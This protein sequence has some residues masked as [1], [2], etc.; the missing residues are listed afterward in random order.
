MQE[1]LPFFL[2]LFSGVFFSEFFRRLHVPWVAALVLGGIIIGPFGLGLFEASETM[3]FIGEIGLIFLM[4][5]AG[6]ET[7]LSSF[8]EFR[9]DIVTFSFFNTIIPFAVG[10]GIAYI[11][12]LGFLPALLIGTIF[13]SSSIPVISPA[14][15][16]IGII[17]KRVGQSII[18]STIV[19]DVISL[20]VLSVIIQTINPTTVLPLWLFYFLLVIVLFVLRWGIGR[21]Q[22]LFALSASKEAKVVFQEELRFVFAILI[23]VV[24]SF[25][26]LGL[27]PI[28]AGFFAGLVLSDSVTHEIILEKLHVMS[29]GLFIPTF[30][31]IIGSQM[32]IGF[33]FEGGIVLLLSITIIVGSL[34][35]KFFSGWISGRIAG[36]SNTESLLVGASATPRLST[37]MAVSVTGLALGLITQELVSIV[38]LLS[39]ISTVIGPSLIRS[40]GGKLV[41]EPKFVDQMLKKQ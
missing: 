26:F 1:I 38:I 22:W 30:F 23:G 32:D 9:K 4:F 11:F 41:S 19:Q 29:Y 31:I 6:L 20:V 10:F 27:H 2:V 15:E 35:S 7:K 39:L 24:A 25:E 14:L 18:A 12:N 21:I 16:A 33:I 28:I 8:R 40:I 17:H 34:G 5:M 3:E 36:Y 13:S 37:A